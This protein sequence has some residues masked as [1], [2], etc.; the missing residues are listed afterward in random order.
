L[1][2]KNL[3]LRKLRTAISVFAVAVGIMTLLVLL[4]LTR[5]TIGEVAERMNSVRGD[6]LVFDKSNSTWVKRTMSPGYARKIAGLENVERVVPVL[7]ETV[8]LAGQAQTI[9]AVETRDFGVFGGAESLVAGRLF[10][11]DAMEMVVDSML[12]RVGH[13]K[14]GDKVEHRD[15]TYTIV[16][17]AKEGVVGRVFL[18]YRTA[19][20]LWQNGEERATMLVVKV[21]RPGAVPDVTKAIEGLGLVVVSKGNYYDVI[22]HDATYLR[23]FIWS[24]SFVTLF[25]S[26]LTILLTMFTIVQEQTREVGILKSLGATNGYIVRLVM[27]QSLVICSTGLVFGLG[28]SFSAKIMIQFFAPLLTVRIDLPLVIWAIIVGIIG[29]LLGALYP[30]LRA[31][32][33]D[34]VETLGYE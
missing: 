5:G 11:P 13:L 34:P 10:E 23:A 17:I 24:T 1:A 19:V 4:G 30:A 2:I 6:L 18:P 25:V 31:A 3:Q 22:A 32:R 9:Y 8:S 15:E 26:F 16:G 27:A 33:L 14:I 20:R 21:S 29:G 12:A 7:N 28:L